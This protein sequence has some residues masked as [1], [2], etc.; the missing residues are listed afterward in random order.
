MEI[1]RVAHLY[2][3]LMNLYGENGNVRVLVN[4]L[5][6]Q[7]LKVIT[8]YLSIEDKIDF[9]KYDIFYLGCGSNESF[10]LVLENIKQYKEAIKKAIKDNKFF[11]VTGTSLN[12]FGKSYLD[13]D[14][15]NINTLNILNY[16][17][18]EVNYRIVDEQDFSFHNLEDD[19][20][21]FQNRNTILTDVDELHLFEVIKGCGY[22]PDSKYEGITKNNFYGTYLL[23]PILVRNPHFT[24]YLVKKI[25]ESKNLPYHEYQNEIET[26]A[27]QVYLNEVIK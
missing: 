10:K 17:S 4:H 16:H 1:I 5:E 23:G 27:Y 25:M 11:I 3:D 21:G 2:Y 6:K 18:E 8:D 13:L 26:K 12:L 20:I 22:L 19:V 15:K 24:E 9:T 7:N 14:K